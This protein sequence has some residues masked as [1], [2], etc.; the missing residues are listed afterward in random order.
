QREHPEW[1]E[2]IA[3]VF[4]MLT[5]M[6]RDDTSAE[7]GVFSSQSMPQHDG[8]VTNNPGTNDRNGDE[9]DAS[10]A[11]EMRMLAETPPLQ[12]LGDF[13]IVRKVG[14]GGM[15][16]VYEAYQRSLNRRVALKVLANRI[17]EDSGARQRFEQEARAVATL[18]H[19]NIVAVY[20]IGQVENTSYMVM[21]FIDGQPLDTVIKELDNGGGLGRVESSSPKKSND[22]S[23]TPNGHHAGDS[24]DPIGSS[25][26]SDSQHHFWRRVADL[27]RQAASALAHAH[28][29]GIVHRDIKPSNLM[30]QPDGTLWVTDFGLAKGTE[31]VDLTQTGQWVGTMRYMSPEQFRGRAIAASDIYS[32]GLTLYELAARKPAHDHQDPD[33]LLLQVQC[34][35]VPRLRRANRRVPGDLATII[36][37]CLNSDPERR[38]ADAG[39]LQD[40]LQRFLN[41]EPIRA[42][43]VGQFER[44]TKWTRRQPIVASLLLAFIIALLTGIAGTA[45]QWRRA[46][47]A[48]ILAE[49][50]AD[51]AIRNQQTA[52][53]H[54]QQAR[55]TVSEFLHDIAHNELIATP[56]LQSLRYQFLQQ[57]LQYHQQFITQYQENE[58]LRKDYAKSLY[59]VAELQSQLNPSQ[60][61]PQKDLDQALQIFQNLETAMA[62]QADDA[63]ESSGE[64]AASD[65]S[66]IRMELRGWQARV[67]QMQSQVAWRT[68]AVESSKKIQQA[69]DILVPL[70]QQYPHDNQLLGLLA[71]VAQNRGI[72]Q[73]SLRTAEADTVALQCYTMAIDARRK[74]A[75]RSEK[76]FSQ[77]IQIASLKRDLGIMH[78]RGGRY[79]QAGDLYTD[80][81]KDLNQAITSGDGNPTMA[82]AT[83][84]SIANTAGFLYGSGRPDKDLSRAMQ[85]YETSRDEY[86]WLAQHNPAVPRYRDGIARAMQ[87][88]GDVANAM[89]DY[90]T[91]LQNR[92]RAVQMIRQM[93]QQNPSIP[94]LHSQLGRALDG[95]AA[96]HRSMKRFDKAMDMH[97]MA[98]KEHQAAYSSD[99]GQTLYRRRA[100][101]GVSMR[102]RTL[103]AAMNL[104]QA[105]QSLEDFDEHAE[106][107]DAAY[108]RARETLLV[109]VPVRRFDN[110]DTSRADALIQRA[111]T[112]LVSAAKQGMPVQSTWKTDP[113][114]DELRDNASYTELIRGFQQSAN[115]DGEL[116]DE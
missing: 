8:A 19:T 3:Q 17:A 70:T 102:I 54:F 91:A 84:A 23:S 18:H 13:D 33:Q 116:S 15:G 14:R 113:A 108:Q 101:N 60:S 38:Y 63:M 109:A 76:P 95:L 100:I 25:M 88:L 37:K 50:R 77:L 99:P 85:C 29:Q 115:T 35:D 93:V 110:P 97:T 12:H 24:S 16:I 1:S 94:A 10:F 21:Q 39:K 65:P 66:M 11:E 81:M 40:D 26:Q 47:S 6:H 74:I 90:E 53:R 98:A 71:S 7:D 9:S 64:E 22:G 49:R 103:T 78:R 20:G 72:Q 56:G 34:G 92:T 112:S 57:A 2:R 51:Q 62:G 114:L 105:I 67:M 55:D 48:R 59:Y 79:D 52:D 4:P 87:S 58:T 46:E 5:A 42:R 45:Y 32:L 89:G 75:N 104:D 28:A 96:T 61:N 107:P 27:G 43:A 68:D 106:L 83:L 73:E 80:A 111:I 44:F 86:M 41:N 30:L 36:D 31:S 69:Y 82:H